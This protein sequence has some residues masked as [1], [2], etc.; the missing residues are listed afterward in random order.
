MLG[1]PA[2]NH[3]FRFNRFSIT[4]ITFDL[5]LGFF[6]WSAVHELDTFRWLDH[7]SNLI[8]HVDEVRFGLNASGKAH[9]LGNI[10]ANQQ[11]SGTQA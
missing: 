2:A 3:E 4:L 7:L 6:I 9:F 11:S 10:M 1:N 8:S 5:V